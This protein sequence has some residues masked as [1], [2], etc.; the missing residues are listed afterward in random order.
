MAEFA[1][2]QE[3]E[4]PDL[5]RFVGIARR[6]H[7]EFLIPLF[8]GW[9]LVWGASWIL[10]PRYKSITTVLV[11]QPAMPQAYVVPNISEDDLQT[12]LQSIQTQIESQTRLLLVINQLHLYGGER[13]EKSSDEKV[14]AMRKDIDLELVR[15]P[16]KQDISAF[17][18]SY[19]ANNPHV[20]QQVTGE[21][22]ELFI[23]ENNKVRQ[24]QSQGTT[25]FLEKQLDDASASLSEQ[26]AKVQ[27]FESQHAGTLPTQQ[28]SNLQI[29]AGLQQQ[30]QNEQDAL[31][32]AKTQH[33]FLQTMLEQERANPT[34]ARPAG[35]NGA[36]AANGAA[37]LETTDQ[38][39]AK[40]RAQLA[41]LSSRYTDKYPDVI[42][43][44]SQIAKTEAI[45]ANLAAAQKQVVKDVASGTDDSALSETARQFQSQLQANELEIKNRENT[46]SGLNAKIAEYQGRLN[47]EPLTE[48]E[49]A[50]LNRGYTQSKTNYDDLL[51]KKT[52]SQMATSMEQAQQGER[53]TMLDPPSL[54]TKPD[55]PNRLKFSGMGL[56]IGL[57]LGVLVAGCF[58]F[59]DDRLHG[60]KEITALLS[61]AVIS[62]IPEVV[63]PSDQDRK[64]KRQVLGWAAT[65]VVLTTIL[66]G[67]VLSFIRT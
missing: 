3:S 61:M 41:D 42:N 34:K 7:V 37:D 20:A 64:K 62:E 14:A 2:E 30:L 39:L 35:A 28:A 19:T 52:D 63:N 12:R 11:E 13:R 59:F 51:K 43:L 38:Q 40:M 6:R 4:R 66:A 44:K 15:D 21:L 36:P 26:D 54:P 48:Q 29:L 55:F 22:T 1:E 65:A 18:V 60:E 16:G 32:A 24:Q 67:T 53:F 57:A 33:V 27:Q 9:L 31:N 46:I 49:L 17:T 10:P 58:E 56:G 5:G 25:D 50:N 47:L 8:L 23:S 45:R